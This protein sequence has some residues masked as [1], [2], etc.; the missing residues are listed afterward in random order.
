MLPA[1]IRSVGMEVCAPDV[2]L[3]PPAGAPV[4]YVNLSLHA[5]RATSA[6]KT[7][8]NCTNAL[9]L[10][11]VTPLTL[12]DQSGAMSPFMGSGLNSM[13][14]P[15]VLVEALPA[16][17]F[18]CS[19]TGNNMIAGL[20]ATAVPDPTNV[21]YSY[22]S[23]PAPAIHEVEAAGEMEIE[24]DAGAERGGLPARQDGPYSL[25][26][27]M[28]SELTRAVGP[29]AGEAFS[30]ELCGEVA[31]VAIPVFT[32][33]LPS[34]VHDALRRLAPRALVL[35]LRGCPGGDLHAALDLA[36][37]FLPE[38]AVLATLTDGDG[39]DTVVRSRSERPLE[40][41]LAIL[42]DRRTAS[43]AE[44]FAGCLKAHGRAVVLGERTYGKGVV[45]QIVA[46]ASAPGA[47]FAT[48]AVVTLPGGLGLQGAGVEPDVSVPSAGR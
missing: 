38:G 1:N 48:T 41:P 46:D 25:T 7:Y 16:T 27:A 39:D 37:D 40:L 29:S 33:S 24:R 12:G 10:G 32:T 2:C 19:A 28:V 15:K 9:N 23:A 31:C 5:S 35:D 34:L 14:N 44:A 6:L 22:S 8:I 11:S 30:A 42:V 45:Q 43:A 26:A 17:S 4:P 18:G 36:G 3:T 13:G 47:R 20:G 21:F